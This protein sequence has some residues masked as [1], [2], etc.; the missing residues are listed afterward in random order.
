MAERQ[1]PDELEGKVLEALRNSPSPL[2]ALHIAK[3]IGKTTAKDVNPTLYGLEKKG[4]VCKHLDGLTPMWRIAGSSPASA[5][6]PVP[7]TEVKFSPVRR[8]DVLNQSLAAMTLS[9]SPSTSSTFGDEASVPQTPIYRAVVRYCHHR[10]N[11]KMH[12]VVYVYRSACHNYNPVPI[13]I[14]LL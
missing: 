7:A 2:K 10:D 12:S 13:A 8:D 11:Y 3:A 5:T 14:D 4:L 6:L 1:R 9:Q